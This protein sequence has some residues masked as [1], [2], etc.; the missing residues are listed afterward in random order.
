MAVAVV[1]LV[2]TMQQNWWP[3]VGALVT[4]VGAV[5]MVAQQQC[6][7]NVAAVAA[8]AVATQKNVS[9]IVSS[10]IDDAAQKWV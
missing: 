1:T 9:G 6:D 2:V 8:V 10:G 4:A 7:K 3:V 5:T